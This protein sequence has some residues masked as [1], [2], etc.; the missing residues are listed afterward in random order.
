MVMSTS[1]PFY[2]GLSVSG[3]EA[4]F[5]ESL[6]YVS[7]RIPSPTQSHRGILSQDG[8]QD[9]GGVGSVMRNM[10]DSRLKFGGREEGDEGDSYVLAAD[11]IKRL[12][13]TSAL[14]S[15]NQRYEERMRAELDSNLDAFIAR[16]NK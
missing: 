12:Y 4:S 3:G 7:S 13:V 15:N 2:M 14:H 5:C 6:T 1:C 8:D 10:Q 16:R 11:T 9:I